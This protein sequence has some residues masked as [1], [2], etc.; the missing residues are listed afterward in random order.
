M[1]VNLDK[2]D[3]IHLVIGIQ[4]PKT[5]YKQLEEFGFIND[6]DIAKPPPRWEWCYP[7]LETLT[8]QELF[9]LYNKVKSPWETATKHLSEPPKYEYEIYF[10]EYPK[11]PCPFRGWFPVPNDMIKDLKQIETYIKSG[12]LRRIKT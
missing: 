6:R 5:M 2:D 7:T 9:E 4:P 1:K 10:D 11:R 8:E 12:L 3:L